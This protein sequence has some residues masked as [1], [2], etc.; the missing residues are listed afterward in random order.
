MTK[1]ASLIAQITAFLEEGGMPATPSNYE[2]WYRYVTRADRELVEAVDAIRRAN[3]R[4]SIRAMNNLRREIYGH[5]LEGATALDR[6]I[7]QTRE[8]LSSVVA[9]IGQSEDDAR[10]YKEALSGKNRSLGESIHDEIARQELLE[11][12]I[13]ATSAMIEKT[14]RLEA[15]LAMSG[16]EIKALKRELDT[17]QTESRTDPLTGIA[18]R[19]A[20]SDYLDAQAA[21]SLA[22]R[23]ALSLI[24][25]DIDHFKQ[26]NDDW[27][28]HIGDEVLRLV[29]SSLENFCHGIGF[30]ARF[31][32]EEFVI[33]LPGKDVD[34]GFDIAEQFR[35]FIASRV[36]RSKQSSREVGR[37]TLSLGVAQLRPAD[38]LE[39]LIAR[40]DEALYEAKAQG[41][42]RV[43]REKPLLQPAM[44]A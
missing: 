36:I 32:G 10:T 35:D 19:K 6:L 40:A 29:G 43:C 14:T 21:R 11:Q 33:V 39:A 37:V 23:K 41:R 22:D 2:F 38:S 20:F 34:A 13:A 26:F 4:V 8:Q 7:G 44:T 9:T 27:G 16:Q 12:M 25:C 3:G 31:G 28:H 30:P 15:E 1:A 5:S 18:N 42:N 17:A 24:F